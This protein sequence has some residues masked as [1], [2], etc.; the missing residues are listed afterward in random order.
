MSGMHFIRKAEKRRSAL[1]LIE[2]TIAILVVGV[3]LVA[4]LNAF[5]S[6][7]KGRQVADNGAL[8][9]QLANQLLSEI[10]PCSYQDPGS[11]PVFG[12]EAG[13]TR[14]TF[15]DVDDYNGYSENSATL[16]DGTAIAGGTGWKR[17]VTVQYVDPSTLAACPGQDKGL[18]LITVIVTDPRGVKITATALRS[19]SGPYDVPP[20]QT[21]TAVQW[22][23]VELQIG[24]DSGAR[25][26]SGANVLNYVPSA[27]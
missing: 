9:S 15:D 3:M 8:A 20:S 12:P 14:A 18:K 17:A 2:T 11:S 24:S 21:M 16:K 10:L 26:T 25:M 19:S 5:G 1:T 22:V 27:Q 4:A 23:G 7:A 6:L 13:E